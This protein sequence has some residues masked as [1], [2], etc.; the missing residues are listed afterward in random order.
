MSAD[1]RNSIYLWCG[2]LAF[3]GLFWAGLH[4]DMVGGV[5]DS[6][7]WRLLGVAILVNLAQFI[8]GLWKRRASSPD[9]PNHR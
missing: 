9:N 4:F 2:G 7:F 6:W 3:F 5:S 1:A 8:R